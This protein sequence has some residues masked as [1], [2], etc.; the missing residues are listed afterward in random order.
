MA[1][2]KKQAAG[3]YFTVLSV[4]AVLVGVIAY[5]VNT[6]T[7]YFA[8]LGVSAAIMT[9][10]ILGILAEILVLVFAERGRQ[11]LMTD[12]LAVIAAVLL[13]IAFVLL[14]KAR[15]YGFASILTFENTPQNVADLMSA[16]TGIIAC[17]VA[18]LFSIIASFHDVVRKPKTENMAG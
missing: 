18:V 9:F 2:L 4:L 5:L 15:V 6:Q 8:Q 11:D 16:F 17:L 3:F 10:A 12:A 14:I 7:A 1:F 13:M